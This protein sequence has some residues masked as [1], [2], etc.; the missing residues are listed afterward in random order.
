EFG[1]RS[2][3]CRVYFDPFQYNEWLCCDEGMESTGRKH[4]ARI[5]RT[6][7]RTGGGTHSFND[8]T[9]QPRKVLSTPV[10]SG[11]ET[12]ERKY[13]PFTTNIEHLI[14]FRTLTGRQHFYLDHDIMQEFGEELPT[15][16]PPLQKLTFY[17]ND[18]KPEAVDSEITLR[19]L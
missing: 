9:E 13:S 4:R 16:K 3:S 6:C 18:R 10:Y 7:K 5:N 2:S 19:Y 12:G 8:I 15:F 1:F 11:T 17:S 14:P